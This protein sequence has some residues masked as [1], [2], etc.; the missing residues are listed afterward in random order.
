MRLNLLILLTIIVNLAA[1]AAVPP[2]VNYQGKLTKA[3]GTLLPDGTYSMTYAIYNVAMNGVAIWSEINPTV[4][5]KKGLFSVLL[6]S[7]RHLP[8]NIFDGTDRYFGV[9]VGTDPEMTPRQQIAS[10][11]FALKAAVADTAILADKATLADKSTM[12]DKATLA[13][14]ATIANT[15]ITANTANRATLADKATLADN[16]TIANTATTANTAN[17]ANRATLADKATTADSAAIASTVVDGAITGAKIAY[18]TINSNN[19]SGGC[20]GTGQIANNSITPEKIVRGSW[21]SA[22]YENAW[23]DYAGDWQ[24]ARYYKDTVGIVHI[25]GMVKNT[26]GQQLNHIFTLPVGYRPSNRL[27]F[28]TVGN[29]ST[30]GMQIVLIDVLADGKVTLEVNVDRYVALSG[31]SFP[32]DQ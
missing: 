20:V 27:A 29:S 6:G 13:D 18:Q 30:T 32:A 5:V 4:Q 26:A 25:Q 16:A 15:A 14:N 22:N 12:S 17:I 2:M 24:G 28:G 10:V 21:I 31:I 3:D 1:I 9:T 11:P 7:I 19:L 23:Q 8:D